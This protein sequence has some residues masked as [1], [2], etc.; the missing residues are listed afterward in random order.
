MGLFWSDV[1]VYRL[2]LKACYYTAIFTDEFF[3]LVTF[4]YSAVP[5]LSVKRRTLVPQISIA[6]RNDL[7][8]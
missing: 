2:I 7:A 8:E 1:K 6:K 5:A 3:Q 4:N